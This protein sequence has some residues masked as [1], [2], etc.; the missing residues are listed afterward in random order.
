[1]L[2]PQATFGVSET[3]TPLPVAPI[4]FIPAPEKPEA[5]A[6]GKSA[7]NQEFVPHREGDTNQVAKKVNPLLEMLDVQ[8]S[9]L[10][11]SLEPITKRIVV[12]I[13]NAETKEVIKQIP[14]KELLELAEK[15]KEISGALLDEVV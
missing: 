14:P 12:K 9:E 1:M 4:E 10:S 5:G 6:K 7:F 11:V 15:L 8:N 2:T 3:R 13:V